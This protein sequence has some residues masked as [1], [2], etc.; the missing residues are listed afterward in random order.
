MEAEEAG[1]APD[2]QELLRNHP[3]LAPQLAQFFAN[4]EQ[5]DRLATPLRAVAQAAC[6]EA[7][8]TPRPDGTIVR[9]APIRDGSKGWLS[10]RTASCWPRRAMT[11]WRESGTRP[12][13]AIN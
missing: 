10:H 7:A 2:R 4:Q 6:G 12:R 8:T 1:R 13:S 5:F 9:S 11:M 3:E